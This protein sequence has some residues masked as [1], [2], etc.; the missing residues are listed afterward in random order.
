MI[1]PDAVADKH[2]GRIIG[3]IEKAQFDIRA[4]KLTELDARGA[5]RFYQVHKDKPFYESLCQSLDSKP[6]VAMVLRKENA[7]TE[8]RKLIGATDPMK[9]AAG[10]IRAMFGKSIEA[11]AVHG[12]DAYDTAIIEMNQFFTYSESNSFF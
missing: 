5:G 11:N 2:V 8:F 6:I 9:A 7:V 10:T 3:M 12:S 4:I 1:K